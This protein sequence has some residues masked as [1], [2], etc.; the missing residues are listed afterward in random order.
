MLK[1]FQEITGQY[2]YHNLANLKAIKVTGYLLRCLACK[3][4]MDVLSTEGVT[5][6]VYYL[7]MY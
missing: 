2:S 4:T 7:F 3:S 5:L 6:S 1:R